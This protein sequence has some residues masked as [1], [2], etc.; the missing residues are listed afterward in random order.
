M[1][2]IAGTAAFLLATFLLLL[3]ILS[4]VGTAI[5]NAAIT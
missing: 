1:L 5:R 3:V 2:I 4:A